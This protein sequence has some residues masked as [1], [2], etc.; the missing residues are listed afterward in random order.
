LGSQRPSR[1][2]AGPSAASVDVWVGSGSGW[3]GCPRRPAGLGWSVGPCPVGGDGEAAGG[4][5]PRLRR[6]AREPC[7]RADRPVACWTGCHLETPGRPGRA[8]S[9]A[10]P[11]GRRQGPWRTS[12][13]PPPPP[14]PA[15]P[16]AQEGGAVTDRTTTAT[17]H[18][19]P[20]LSPEEGSHG[21][22][23]RHH[24]RQPHRQPRAQAHRKRQPGG[25]LPA[26]RHR[27]GQGR[28]QLARRRHLVLPD[29]RVAA[30]GRARRRVPGQRRPGGGDRPAQVPVL[31]D[32]PRATSARWSRSRPTR[33]PPRCGGRSPSP[34]EP[35]TARARPSSTTTPRSDP[36]TSEA[37]RL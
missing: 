28:R 16:P 8:R 32:P 35:P 29:Q 11:A 23:P 14:G 9:S 19:A 26:G 34:S 4:D 3:G 30:A 25:Q 5:R 24:H 12:K 2:S 27:K 37:G 36:R 21:R 22:H 13:G 33:S 6:R 7:T 10:R 18:T 17:E 15:D 31:G 1:L 20:L